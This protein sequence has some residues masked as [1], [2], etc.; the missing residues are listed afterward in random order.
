VDRS[1]KKNERMGVMCSPEPED[2]R[3]EEFGFNLRV[4]EPGQFNA[5]YHREN[6]QEAFFRRAG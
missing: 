5:R 4:L 6:A 1:L 3:F 2:V